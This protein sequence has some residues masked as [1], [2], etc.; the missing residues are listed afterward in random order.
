MAA[1]IPEALELN[2]SYCREY[3]KNKFSVTQMVD[4]YEAAYQQLLK[5]RISLNG[6]INAP[7]LSI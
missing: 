1:M 3:V 2:R 4:G 6:H 7:K 5:S